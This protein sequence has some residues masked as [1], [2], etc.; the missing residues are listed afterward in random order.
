MTAVDPL[1][2]DFPDLA[3]LDLFVSVVRLGSVGKAAVHHRISQPAA[4]GRMRQLER[5]VGTRLLDRSPSGSTPTETGVLVEAWARSILEAAHALRAGLEAVAGA[6]RGHLHVAASFTLAEYLVPGWI[7]I[8][9]RRLPDVVV[10][11]DVENSEHVEAAVR[12]GDVEIGFVESPGPWPKLEVRAVGGD[13]LA[14]VVQAGHPWAEIGRVAAA[15][16]VTVPLVLRE[17]GSGTRQI[18]DRALARAEI[19]QAEAALEAGSTASILSAV[20][21]SGIPGV[22][23]RLAAAGPGLVAVEIEGA[24]VERSFAAIRRPGPVSGA[25]AAL[26]AVAERG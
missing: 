8:M 9:R 21:T 19:G 12:A 1:P 11:L 22:V 24:D 16:L 10:E 5:Q 15:E 7:G 17:A 26:L 3:S 6:E 25:A 14:V 13:R 4:S 18:L 2:P 20:R 23:S